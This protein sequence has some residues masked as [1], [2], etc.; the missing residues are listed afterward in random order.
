M[1]IKRQ[2]IF[3]PVAARVLLLLVL[4][5]LAP[6]GFTTS[7]FAA[8]CQTAKPLITAVASVGMTVEDLDRSVEFYSS[9]LFF[10]KIREVELFGNSW[11]RLEGVFSLRIR[12]A[13]LQ[14]G[15]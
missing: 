10:N 6:A 5:L 2:S 7:P 1:R 4:V 8:H 14:R 11:E 3:S 12:I 15:S 13:W 9:V